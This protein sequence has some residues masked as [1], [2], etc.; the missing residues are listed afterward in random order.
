[1]WFR[2]RGDIL[3][4]R[5]NSVKPRVRFRKRRQ[6]DRPVPDRFRGD[7]RAHVDLLVACRAP[8][9][10]ERPLLLVQRHARVTIGTIDIRRQEFCQESRH[11]TPFVLIT[12]QPRR[13]SR[14]ALRYLAGKA[15]TAFSQNRKKHG[16]CH[17]GLEEN[18][19][20]LSPPFG[21]VWKDLPMCVTF[22]K[23]RDDR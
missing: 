13:R 1:M 12:V 19:V 3:L 22:T 7:A 4:E 6:P 23:V 17:H 21:S 9:P 20:E 14:V 18:R 11:G 2:W 15:D 16:L 10:L 5:R 8:E